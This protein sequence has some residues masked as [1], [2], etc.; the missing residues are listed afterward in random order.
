MGFT[1]HRGRS[2]LKNE[3]NHINKIRNSKKKKVEKKTTAIQNTVKEKIKKDS[4]GVE[5]ITI[6]NG[7]VSLAV[8]TG[9]LGKQL[10]FFWQREEKLLGCLGWGKG[11]GVSKYLHRL[12]SNSTAVNSMS[13]PA[14]RGHGVCDGSQLCSY[15][16][17]ACRRLES[18]FLCS[19]SMAETL[20]ETVG[21]KPSIQLISGHQ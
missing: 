14:F 4:Q 15:W 5:A 13:H 18:C 6:T 9:I 19:L 3:Q 20:W 12:S 10:P 16:C 2:L 17:S 7:C 8:P 11:A 1:L 21:H